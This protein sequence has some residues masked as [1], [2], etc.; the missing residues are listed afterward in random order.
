MTYAGHKQIPTAVTKFK[1]KLL[2]INS[3][4]SSITI[5][6]VLAITLLLHHCASSESTTK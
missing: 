1:Y 4:F 3:Y 6:F 2:F 5:Y